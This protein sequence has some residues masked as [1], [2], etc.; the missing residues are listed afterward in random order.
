MAGMIVE[1]AE[2]GQE[3]FG[4]DD[5]RPELIRKEV[6]RKIEVLCQDEEVYREFQL[7]LDERTVEQ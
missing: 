5:I 6:L 2:S 4:P 1:D 7:F 3:G